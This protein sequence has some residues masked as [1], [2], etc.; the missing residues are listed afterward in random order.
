MTEPTIPPAEGYA[1]D[2]TPQQAWQWVQNGQAV[3]VDVRSDAEREWVGQVPGAAAVAWKQWP[4][5][6]MNA[7]FDAQMRAAVPAG[8]P[9][10]LLCRS[11]VRSIA[12]AR[13]A[14][15]L[16]L[17]AY[18]ILEGFEGDADAQ[19]HRGQR[20]GWRFHGLPWKQG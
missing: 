19:G 2:I 4:G 7:D 11:G 8:T 9:A 16:G 13:R 17:T 3:L 12:A 5:M 6:A 14:T 10:V 20:G 1:G 18:N 15:E